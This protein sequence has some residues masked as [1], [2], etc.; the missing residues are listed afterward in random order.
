MTIDFTL[1]DPLYAP[2]VQHLVS[3]CKTAG[4]ALVPYYGYRTL[5]QQA[6]LWRRSRHVDEVNE[7][8]ESLKSQY[9]DYLASILEGVGPQPM[10]PWATDAIPGFSWHNWGQ[11]VD[12][13]WLMDNKNV[14]W[15]GKGVGYKVLGQ[16]AD[17]LDL[18]WGGN[19]SSPDYGHVQLNHQEVPDLYDTKYVNDYFKNKGQK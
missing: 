9:C 8:I 5:E 17:L 14:C 11:A 12:F 2:L 16:Q 3:N 6:I 1:L 13:Y 7:K 4:Y 19:F 15:D 10:G 18:R